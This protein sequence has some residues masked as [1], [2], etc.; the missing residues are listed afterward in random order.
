VSFS[1]CLGPFPE[2]ELA[3]ASSLVEDFSAAAF[4]SA[5]F[6]TLDLAF[7]V[8][9]KTAV[10]NLTADADVGAVV[11]RGYSNREGLA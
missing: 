2:L 4:C 11:G 10:G 1:E 5:S 3:E 8:V 7:A 6:F 9:D